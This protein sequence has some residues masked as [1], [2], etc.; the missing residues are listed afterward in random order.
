M[1]NP[2]SRRGFLRVAGGAGLGLGLARPFSGIPREAIAASGGRLIHEIDCTRDYLPEQYFDSGGV[3]VTD[4]GAGRYR[5]AAPESR[6]RF[7]YR[8]SIENT[9]APHVAVIRYPDD[10]QRF[11]CI[12]DG[13]SYDLT[14]GLFTGGAQPLTGTMQEVRQLFW[15][16]WN[17]CSIVFMTWGEGEPAAA[18]HIEIRELE[19]LAALDVPGDP[20]D[21]TR[22]EIGI[23]YEDPCG[24]AMSEGAQNRQEWIE[25]YVQYAKYT[26]QQLL[27]HPMAWYHGPIFPSRREPSGALDVVSAP[28]RTQ[29]IR[30]TSQP[31]D[32]FAGLLQRFGEEGLAFQGSLTLLRLGSLMEKMNID[33]DA[34]KGGADTYNNLLWNDQVQESTR[35][36]TPLYNV[37]NFG[38]IAELLKDRPSI[39]PYGG[40]VPPFVYGE[41]QNGAYHMGPLFNPLHPTV[42]EAILGFVAELG[43]RYRKYPAFKGISFNMFGSCMLWYGSLHAG[44]D[45]YTIGL[46]EAETGIRVPVDPKAPDRFSQRYAFLVHTCRPAWVA[47]R[48]RKIRE[49]FG[50]V[51]AA[52]SA[53]RADLRVTV[54]LWSETLILGVYGAVSEPHQLYARPATHVLFREAGIDPALYGDVPGLVVDVE[55]GNPRDRGGHPP[56]P[57]SGINTPPESSSMYRDFDFLDSES[58]DVYAGHARPGVFIFN[59][60][61]EAWGRHVWAL[62]K[63]DDPNLPAVRL[64]DGVPADGVFLINSEYP[65][66]AF[67]W[68]SQS[69]ITPPFPGGVHFLEPYAHAL[70][71]L[72]A[73]RITRGGLFLDKAHSAALRQFAAAYRA[74]PNVKFEAVG[75]ASDP[76]AVRTLVHDGVRYIYAVNR[77][78]YPVALE[79]L[80]DGSVDAIHD[81]AANTPIAAGQSWPTTLGPYELRVLSIPKEYGVKGFSTRVPPEIAADLAARAAVA[82][83]SFE[84]LRAQGNHIPGMDLLEVRIREALAEGRYAWLR[85]ALS[86]YIVRKAGEAI[87]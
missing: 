49:L 21:G 79:L 23:Q 22:R 57:S 81:L 11:M 18:T 65:E 80:F 53:A 71:E 61:V 3:H 69:R 55:Q 54:T 38:G 32:W 33:L 29:Y 62:P 20:G 30:W 64:M 9:G 42:Q 14:T 74:L 44:Y 15:P 52:L 7:G 34:I 19:D 31:Q 72:D 1:K 75:A 63:P 86:G 5:E 66:D 82:F 27:V 46:F 87:A 70:A 73:C 58:L 2:V 16:R 24:S 13:S 12:M 67:W 85:R 76:V 36:W 48:C 45:D 60:W 78:Y 39:E 26:G 6:S 68:N 10:T 51:H 77:D 59:C 8:F 40:E 28:D 47:W 17:D 41:R 84:Q 83:Q 35:D 50:K 25:R 56:H 43:E 4:G 37:R